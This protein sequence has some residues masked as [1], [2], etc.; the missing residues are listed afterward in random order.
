MQ[1]LLL[2]MA[3]KIK[4]KSFMKPILVQNVK[5]CFLY[6]IMRMSSNAQIAGTLISSDI[7]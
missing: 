3:V 5:T 1:S 4:E 2:N 7:I 6:Q